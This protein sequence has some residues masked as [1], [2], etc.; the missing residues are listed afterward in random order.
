MSSP[1]NRGNAP[2]TITWGD[3]TKNMYKIKLSSPRKPKS[4]LD[5]EEFS[6]ERPVKVYDDKEIAAYIAI[7][8]PFNGTG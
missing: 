3:G 5:M 8:L 2:R 7:H 1:Y 6:K 4:L